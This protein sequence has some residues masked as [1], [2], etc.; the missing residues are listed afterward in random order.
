MTII[1]LS[2]IMG[3]FYLGILIL[4]AIFGLVIGWMFS[5]I[6]IPPSDH[7]HKSYVTI[8]G[9]K[10][11]IAIGCAFA[12]VVCGGYLMAKIGALFS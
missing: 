9:V 8:I 6:L 4:L 10:I 5:E 12:A 1:I 2:T 3:Y 7:W 11:G